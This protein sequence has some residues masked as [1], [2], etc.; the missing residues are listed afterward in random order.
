MQDI[1]L[2]NKDKILNVEFADINFIDGRLTIGIIEPDA[3]KIK[4]IQDKFYNLDAI[5]TII[6]ENN[7]EVYNTWNGYVE[8]SNIFLNFDAGRITIWLRKENK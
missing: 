1:I 3:V 4:T 7:G 8:L 6:L 2:A 5:E